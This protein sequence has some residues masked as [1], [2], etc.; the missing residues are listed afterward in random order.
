MRCGRRDERS[1]SAG[2]G[3][4]D[5]EGRRFP[6]DLAPAQRHPRECYARLPIRDADVPLLFR[7]HSGAVTSDVGSK[8]IS[9][10]AFSSVDPQARD[11]HS[12]LRH[13][14][15]LATSSWGGVLAVN[16][17][18]ESEA[19]PQDNAVSGRRGADATRVRFAPRP[20]RRVWISRPPTS[21]CCARS[22]LQAYSTASICSMSKA[23]LA[24]NWTL[25]FRTSGGLPRGED[26]TAHQR[27]YR[28]HLFRRCPG[29]SLP[30][31]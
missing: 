5:E 25:G 11:C 3:I 26:E 9:A 29:R 2:I 16:A 18:G 27:L 17:T 8:R 10:A 24:R 20:K 13:V 21:H 15:K 23:L 4:G 7:S 6:V 28:P 14:A 1:R 22:R 12:V 30:G 31:S 19:A